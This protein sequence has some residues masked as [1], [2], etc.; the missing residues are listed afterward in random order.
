MTGGYEK[1]QET[2]SHG[3]AGAG[4]EDVHVVCSTDLSRY[5]ASFPLHYWT[6]FGSLQL[7]QEVSLLVC[8]DAAA[9]DCLLRLNCT[10]ASTGTRATTRHL[11]LSDG[12]GLA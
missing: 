8:C 5:F 3:T 9:V 6:T 10:G 2:A 4:H 1:R 12:G 11:L 7:L